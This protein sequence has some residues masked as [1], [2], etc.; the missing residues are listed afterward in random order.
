MTTSLYQRFLDSKR[1]VCG[2]IASYTALMLV[3]GFVLQYAVGLVPC[4]L[5]IIQRFFFGLVGVVGLV[6][7]IHGRFLNGYAAAMFTL[8]SLGLLVAARNVYIEWAP[9]SEFG[10]PCIPW[11]ESLTDW[12]T[13]VFQATGDCTERDWTMLGL[14]IPEWSLFSFL[15]LMLVTAAMVW[16]KARTTPL[17]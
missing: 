14:S 1:I 5:C 6:G 8:S 2:L 10:A 11:L 4:P 12:V 7:A 13:V 15:F 17:V 9:K 3:V 16:G